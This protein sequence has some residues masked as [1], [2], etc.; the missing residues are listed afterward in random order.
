MIMP[1]MNGRE[2]YNKLKEIN[3]EVKVLL[4]SGYS[5]NGKAQEL[6]NSGVKDFLQKPYE[7][8]KLLIKIRQV[9]N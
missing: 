2:T 5:R 7:F 4:S 1:D 6:I 3:S 8:E 9:L